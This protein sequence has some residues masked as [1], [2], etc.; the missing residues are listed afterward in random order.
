MHFVA[1]LH[2]AA[3][4]FSGIEQFASKARRHRLFGTLLSRFAEPAHRK[5]HAADGADFDRHLVVGTTDAAGLD[6]HQRTDV[7]EGGGEHFQSVLAG[8]FF[9]LREGA[10]DDAFGDGLLTIEHDHV[11]KLGDFDAAKLRI[12][13]HFAL[14]Y[15]ATTGHLNS[16]LLQSLRKGL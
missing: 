11:D 16:S 6:F 7:V 10:V 5:S 15:F 8:L 4:A 12:R 9:D 3:A 13:Q 2:S 1:L 14:G